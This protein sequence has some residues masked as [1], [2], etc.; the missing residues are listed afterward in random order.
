M[1][2]RYERPLSAAVAKSPDAYATWRLPGNAELLAAAVAPPQRST[3]P[4][5]D[6]NK[7]YADFGKGDLNEIYRILN[8]DDRWALCLSG[9]C[10]RSAALRTGYTSFQLLGDAMER[11]KTLDHS[12]LAGTP[13][14]HDHHG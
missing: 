6:I 2:W 13:R 8:K 12:K 11:A 4:L 3:A 1:S 9:G 14:L 7:D 10:I 5:P